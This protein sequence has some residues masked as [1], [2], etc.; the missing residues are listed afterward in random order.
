M[1][2]L[3]CPACGHNINLKRAAANQNVNGIFMLQCA[4][5][6]QWS[7]ESSKAA[8]FKKIGLVMMIA[9]SAMGYFQIGGGIIG[10]LIA[11]VGGLIALTTLLAMPR[12]IYT[13]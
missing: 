4:N 12:T 7:H 10:P 11:V 13:S 8:F 6:K 3:Q 9:G 1:K 2:L 5:C